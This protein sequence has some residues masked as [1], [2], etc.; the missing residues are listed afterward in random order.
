MEEQAASATAASGI[1][2]R[3]IDHPAKF[4]VISDLQLESM[5]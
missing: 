3:K 5:G 1:V 2:R 4:I